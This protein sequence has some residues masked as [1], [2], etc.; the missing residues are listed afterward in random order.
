MN[1]TPLLLRN[2]V[3]QDSSWVG[4]ELQG[5]KS[6]RDAI[7]AKVTVIAGTRHFVRWIVGGSSYISSSDKRVLVGLG[8]SNGEAVCVEVLWPSGARQKLSNLQVNR[9]LKIVEG[10][11]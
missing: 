5:T 3:G 1:G 7:G 6:N 9:Y 4:F 2:N 8:H 11:Q 10:T